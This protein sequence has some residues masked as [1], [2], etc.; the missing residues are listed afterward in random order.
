MGSIASTGAAR[1]HA[2]IRAGICATSRRV[3]LETNLSSVWSPFSEAFVL[4]FPL[5]FALTL[6]F[7][8]LSFPRTL[9]R[10]RASLGKW[11]SL[12]GDASSSC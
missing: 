8:P 12:L 2:P 4:T 9:V 10:R 11:K 7:L 3:V 6:A 5:A 1:M